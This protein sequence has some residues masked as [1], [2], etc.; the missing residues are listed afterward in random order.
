MIGEN[1]E[2]I[3]LFL[4]LK[5]I[6]NKFYA[7][8]KEMLTFQQIYTCIK[9]IVYYRNMFQLENLNKRGLKVPN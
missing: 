3:N 2:T 1:S 7:V 4:I 8:R 6:G 9:L 5:L